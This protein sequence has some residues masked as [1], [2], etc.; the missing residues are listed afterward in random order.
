M[1]SYVD[2]CGSCLNFEFEGDNRKGYCTWYRQY[3]W[4]TDSCSP[5]YQSREGS[6]SCYITTIICSILG[7]EDNCNVLNQ[8]R[9]FR[10]NVMQRQPEYAP[11]LYEYDTVGPQIAKFMME[12]YEKDGNKDFA[13]L[14]FQQFI[15]PTATFIEEGKEQ[16][17]VSLYQSMTKGLETYYHIVKPEKMEEKYDSSKGGH[18]KVYQKLFETEKKA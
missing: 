3:F 16:E 10:N 12:D 4:P 5:H 9:K 7:L 2:Q 13:N 17:A 8:L 1:A 18:G 11:M 6:S 15:Q 14:L